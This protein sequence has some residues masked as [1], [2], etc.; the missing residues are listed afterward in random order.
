MKRP[1]FVIL[2]A[3]ITGLSLGWF[4][5]QRFGPSMHLTIL[6]KEPRAGGWIQTDHSKNFVFEQGPHSCRAVGA[7][8]KTLQLIESLGLERQVIPPSLAAKKRFLYINQKLQPIPH[9]LISFLTSP[10]AKGVFS[11]LWNEWRA[12]KGT[13]P[14][15][16][17][18]DF[19][20]RRFSPQM[21]ER[22]MDPLTSGIYAGDIRQLSIKSCFPLLHQYEQTYGS[23]LKG[24]LTRKKK[25]SLKYTP[26]IES[27]RQ[28][29]Q[30]SFRQ[31]METLTK[32]LSSRLVEHLVFECEVAAIHPSHHQIQVETKGSA[33]FV[34][35]HLFATLPAHRLAK[36]F[37]GVSEQCQKIPYASVAVVNLGWHRPILRQQGFGYLIPTQEQE[38]ILGVVWDSSAFP[39][40]NHHLD[41]TRLTV[42]IGGMHRDLT[43]YSEQDLLKMA[44][45]SLSKHLQIETPPDSFT[46]KIAEQAIPQYAVG[47]SS[48]VETLKRECSSIS[49]RI[50]LIGSSYQGVSINDCI[51][52]AAGAAELDKLLDP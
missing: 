31:G 20:S 28:H 15:E 6:E 25:N 26:F 14:D 40:Q 34:A 49:S 24:M 8:I 5:K 42:M 47:H 50:T 18:Y 35:D 2:G 51:A 21:A 13:Q 41:E 23:I 22:F 16:S 27:M 38:E 9:R 30:F 39:Q 45:K 10:L 3:G 36:I 48:L 52:Q 43:H 7:G 12:P 44:Q 19:I 32:E 17:I 4:L 1:H 29:S 33:L 46:V 11:S 37:S